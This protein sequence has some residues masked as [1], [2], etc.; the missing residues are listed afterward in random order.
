MTR[1]RLGYEELRIEDG[2]IPV[3][4]TW[5]YASA[6]TFTIAGDVTA[7]YTKGTKLKF[8]QTTVKYG[9]VAS[10][11][12]SSPNTTVTILV[13]TDY[14]IAN[15]AISATS[16][17]RIELPLGWPGWFN[18][19]A[20]AFNVS[21]FDNGA[22]GQPTTTS[23]RYTVLD[24]LVIAQYAGSGVKA[25][26]SSNIILTT[27]S[28]PVIAAPNFA[29]L[30]MA[31]LGTIDQ[32]GSTVHNGATVYIVMN[33]TVADNQNIAAWGFTITYEW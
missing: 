9:I 17:S 4:N 27:H 16:Y 5:T 8:T 12:Y 31:Y 3:T 6:S 13:N 32:V 7:I 23:C 24:R 33:A 15:A 11:S 22:G 1:P 25:N 14:V 26:T 28:F 2:W 20:P 21:Y 10:S 19:A 18:V 29:G 30:G